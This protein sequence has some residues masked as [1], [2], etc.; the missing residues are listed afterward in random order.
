MKSTNI[1]ESFRFALAGLGYGLRHERNVRIHSIIGLL[2][3]ILAFY[4]EV[5]RAELAILVLTITTVLTAELLNTAIEAAIDMVTQDYHPLAAL[6]K[7]LAAGAVLT[8][9]MGAAGVGILILGKYLHMVRAKTI[10]VT[11]RTG[12]ILAIV[13]T[14]FVV[15]LVVAVKAAVGSPHGLRGGMPSGHSAL[16]A[17]LCTAVYFVGASPAA[18]ILSVALVLLVAQSRLEAG[19][20]SVP[21]VLVGMGVGVTVTWVLF[22]L[23]AA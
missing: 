10:P 20:H 8:T 23:V 12:L 13:G 5:S 19:I 6:S 2:V 1:I 4:L 22:G 18:V 7:N 9:A 14:V 17:G 3:I 15:L 21:E 11:V 16:A